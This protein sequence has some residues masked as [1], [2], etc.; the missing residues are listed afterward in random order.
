MK[1]KKSTIQIDVGAL[2]AAHVFTMEDYYDYYEFVRIAPVDP[3]SSSVVEMLSTNGHVLFRHEIT[4][5]FLSGDVLPREGFSIPTVI[6]PR[7]GKSGKMITLGYDH[8]SRVIEVSGESA[9][10]PD[11]K[12]PFDAVREMIKEK[13]RPPELSGKPVRMVSG[14]PVQMV[15]LGSEAISNIVKALKLLSIG[16]GTVPFRLYHDSSNKNAVFVEI[17]LHPETNM[18]IMPCRDI[19]WDKWEGK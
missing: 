15:C 4:S 19:E 9:I 13:M 8:K 1:S 14:K 17:P 3:K 11:I 16:S 18:I 6:I 12:W 10:A 7:R 2:R 5:K